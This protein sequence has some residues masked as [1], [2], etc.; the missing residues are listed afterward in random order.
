MMLKLDSLGYIFVADI[1]GLS[2]TTS[3]PYVTSY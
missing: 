3:S 1:M 2:S